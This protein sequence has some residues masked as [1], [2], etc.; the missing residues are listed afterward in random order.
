M[1]PESSSDSIHPM[2][3]GRGI[4][5]P[6]VWQAADAL[7]H[8]GLRPTIER[9]RQKIGSG[10][11]KTVSPML[12]R[13]F[14]TLGQRLGGGGASMGDGVANNLANNGSAN[15][16]AQQLPLAIVQAAQQFWNAAR[17]EAD[18]VQ[19]QKT[20]ATRRELELERSALTRKEADPAP[21][22]DCFRTGP[23]RAR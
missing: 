18:Q 15:H 13:W 8:D 19:I 23:R 6:Q 9:V 1:N 5:E 21:A 22:R 2:R 10:S 14:A 4:Q 7:L 16:E 12:E 3:T 11:P 17:L 20:E